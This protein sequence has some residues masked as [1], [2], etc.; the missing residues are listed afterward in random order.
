[1]CKKVVFLLMQQMLLF[2]MISFD[3]PDYLPCCWIRDSEVFYSLVPDEVWVNQNIQ[4]KIWL[5]GLYFTFSLLPF[6]WNYPNQPL[7][8]YYSEKSQRRPHPWKRESEKHTGKSN[9]H[10]REGGGRIHSWEQQ[11]A[12]PALWVCPS[13]WLDQGHQPPQL[14]QDHG[15][16]FGFPFPCLAEK[17]TASWLSAD[18]PDCTVGDVCWLNSHRFYLKAL[19]SV[20]TQDFCF[21]WSQVRDTGGSH[22]HLRGWIMSEKKEANGCDVKFREKY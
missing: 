11:W 3:L 9:S 4:K 21:T 20:A 18:P 5:S 8:S 12:G 13:C 6:L 14:P 19:L 22:C 2:C 15:C 16:Q 1:M 10:S 17:L 7:C